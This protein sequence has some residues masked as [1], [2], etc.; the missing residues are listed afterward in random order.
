[1]P[2]WTRVLVPFAAG[3]AAGVLLNKYWPQI[4]EIAGPGARKGLER[5]S[6]AL[7]KAKSAFWE[8]SEKFS[9]LIAE[10]RDEEGAAAVAA[11]ADPPN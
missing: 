5:G 1:M 3:V 2:P 7:D 9:D 8:Q 4:K 6:A 11:K 10:I